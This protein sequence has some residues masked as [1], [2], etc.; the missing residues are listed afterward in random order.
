MENDEEGRILCKPILTRVTSLFAEKNNLIYAIPGGLIGVGTLMDPSLTIKDSLVGNI[1]GYP[2]KLPM[3]YSEL[4]I[5]YKLLRRLIGVKKTEGD[6]KVR[7]LM[8]KEVLLFN[9]GSTS[10]TGRVLS[11]ITKY[12]K[13]TIALITPVCT[14][15][16]EKIALSRK[17]NV[18]WR[19]IG[20]GN[21]ISGKTIYPAE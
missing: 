15:V 14:S 20:W 2:G 11:T 19:L 13:A 1:I 21:I 8:K 6:D 5:E 18:N 12:S 16:G 10:S 9:V 4:E 7:N 17:I 3:V